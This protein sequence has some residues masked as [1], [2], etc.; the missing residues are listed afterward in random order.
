MQ[1]GPWRVLRGKGLGVY[2]FVY[3]V[4][5]V[6]QESAG[7]FALKV[8]RYPR[9][10]RFEREGELLSRVRHPHVPRLHDRGE[11]TSPNGESFPYVV[12]DAIDGVTLYAW[13][14]HQ[15]RSLRERLRALEQVARAYPSGPGR[16]GR[17]CGV[18]RGG[19]PLDP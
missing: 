13:A 1:V 6:G 15:P 3:L 17:P 19:S 7:P 9:D 11:W 5:R 14:A 16:A 4:E 10:P 18:E 12:M 2:G 8:A